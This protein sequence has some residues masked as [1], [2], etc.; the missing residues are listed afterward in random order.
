M[1]EYLKKNL[2]AMADAIVSFFGPGCEVAVHDISHME[3][4]L[5]YIAGNVTNR[6]PGAPATDLLARHLA[7][8]GDKAPDLPPYPAKNAVGCQMKGSLTFIRDTSEHIVAA[9]CFNMDISLQ[10]S[11]IAMLQNQIS[12]SSVIANDKKETF[13]NTLSEA[14]ETLVK[15]VLT[16]FGKHPQSLSRE[17]KIELVKNFEMAGAFYFKG[18]VEDVAKI[19]GIS[20]YTLYSYRKIAKNE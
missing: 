17:E 2:I 20:K 15:D 4:S 18:M 5:I 10:I 7:K 6:K 8:Y 3:S 14:S 9:I 12:V 1:K 16:D 13:S 19:M 11:A